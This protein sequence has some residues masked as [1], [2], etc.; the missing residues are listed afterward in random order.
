[1]QV[2]IMQATRN[3]NAEA[4]IGLMRVGASI[5][6]RGNGLTVAGES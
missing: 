4:L 2:N 3:R 1:M 6:E 5:D